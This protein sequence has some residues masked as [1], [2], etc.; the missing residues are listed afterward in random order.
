MSPLI[1]R[2]N[3]MDNK[4]TLKLNNIAPTIN[5]TEM[6]YESYKWNSQTIYVRSLL[7]FN[8]MIQLVEN[9]IASCSNIDQGSGD[10]QIILEKLDFCKRFWIVTYYAMVEFPNS[11]QDQYAIL[12]GTDLYDS[13]KEVIN[14][15]QL[16]AI[17]ECID[18]Y[19]HK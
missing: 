2:G 5:E 16:N 15:G 9:I 13:I 18:L 7:S 1:F 4:Y 19:I 6:K 3:V 10:G 8:E 14:D 12:Y 11:I 17:I